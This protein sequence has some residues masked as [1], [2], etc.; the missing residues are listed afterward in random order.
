MRCDAVR[1]GAVRC[2]AV[3]CQVLS[4]RA[5]AVTARHPA[6]PAR[7]R[8]QCVGRYRAKNEYT[9][10]RTRGTDTAGSI[11]PTRE[12]RPATISHA[13]A[14]VLVHRLRRGGAADRVAV[15]ADLP[16]I[17]GLA[18]GFGQR[19]PRRVRVPARCR[20]RELV[21]HEA[22]VR[23]PG[24]GTVHGEGLP[25]IAAGAVDQ[26]QR[27]DADG[28]WPWCRTCTRR[29]SPA[30]RWPWPWPWPSTVAVPHTH[31]TRSRHSTTRLC[32]RVGGA[33][34]TRH[35]AGRARRPADAHLPLDRPSPPLRPARPSPDGDL[36][37][38]PGAAAPGGRGDRRGPGARRAHA[39]APR[40][41]GRA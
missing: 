6:R 14:P 8:R 7:A 41:A 4:G 10:L 34:R 26:M 38:R 5:Q 12:F 19:A 36:S 23:D 1:C 32:M 22:G 39:A 37:G 30:M 35:Q 11:A 31:R 25:W 2:E 17:E 40:G 20:H 15:D 28:V 9:S 29:S 27:G 16:Q 21:Q 18:K 3:R 24:S 13:D 33:R